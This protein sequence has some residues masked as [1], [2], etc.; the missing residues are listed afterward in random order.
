MLKN[1]KI[2]YTAVGICVILSGI[3]YYIGR[4]GE[5]ASAVYNNKEQTK[6]LA[7]EAPDKYKTYKG[8]D[9]KTHTA[10]IVYMYADM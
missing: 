3:F 1:K 8:A 10:G 4:S 9:G 6:A 7:N 5:N 2:L